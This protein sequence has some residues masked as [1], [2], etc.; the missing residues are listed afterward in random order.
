MSVFSAKQTLVKPGDKV[1]QKMRI[2][3]KNAK[4]NGSNECVLE[5]KYVI[6]EC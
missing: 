5:T 2:E 3:S 6:T 1:K 4:R